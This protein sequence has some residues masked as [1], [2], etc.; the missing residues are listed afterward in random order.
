[1]VFYCSTFCNL[2][3][4]IKASSIAKTCSLSLS[5]TPLPLAEDYV[6]NGVY[7]F[8]ENRVIDG[9]ELEG[10]EWQPVNYENGTTNLSIR[11]RLENESG[12][13]EEQVAQYKAQAQTQ[14]SQTISSASNDGETFTGE[15]IFD[16]EATIS[17]S[18]GVREEGD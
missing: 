7:N 1:M 17:V 10:L 12:L 9:I 15:L 6:Y 3:C 4:F 13:T 11:V 5:F 18:L 16:D 8:S 14:F 2:V